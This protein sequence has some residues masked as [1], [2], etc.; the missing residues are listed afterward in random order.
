MVAA[1]SNRWRGQLALQVAADHAETSRSR[2]EWFDG[3]IVN[4]ESKYVIERERE[5]ERFLSYVPKVGRN[6]CA[7]WTGTY[8]RSKNVGGVPEP[9]FSLSKK[10]VHMRKR[11]TT[12]VTVGPYLWELVHGP[13]PKG[14]RIYRTCFNPACC[15]IRHLWLGTMKDHIANMRASGV[16]AA[17][18]ARQCGN[19]HAQRKAAVIV[20]RILADI[21][22]LK[23]VRMRSYQNLMHQLRPTKRRKAPLARRRA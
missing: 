12:T 11:K 14:G 7:I 18:F 2:K 17:K 21:A 5:I 22:E 6:E 1:V 4:S 20:D 13:V 19:G 9:R 8:I 10:L 15:N 3:P 23:R 16:L